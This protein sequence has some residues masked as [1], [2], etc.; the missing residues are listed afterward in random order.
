MTTATHRNGAPAPA[1]VDL[2]AFGV[3]IDPIDLFRGL[4]PVEFGG[5][6]YYLR[7]RTIEEDEAWAAS[8]NEDHTG[9]LE[10]VR[11]GENDTSAIVAALMTATDQLLD[12]IYA[13][14]TDGALPPREEIKRIARSVD[15][16]RA[17]MTIWVATNPT[18]AT[19]LAT[20]ETVA[21]RMSGTSRGSTSVRSATGARRRKRS[22][23]G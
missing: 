10:A 2:A 19:G 1:P 9:L 13:Y 21:N 23:R 4:I 16:L 7:A 11:Q 20:V 18:L 15:P 5:Q 14:D 22:G 17:C 12:A 3:R 6:R 8:L